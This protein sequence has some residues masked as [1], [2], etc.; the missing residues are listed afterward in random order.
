MSDKYSPGM[1]AIRQEFL[2]HA[3]QSTTDAFKTASK[4]PISKTAKI[5]G[6]LIGN[7]TANRITKI[8]KAIIIT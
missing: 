4:R 5:T 7:K 1:L 6:D 2:D 8:V 3:K